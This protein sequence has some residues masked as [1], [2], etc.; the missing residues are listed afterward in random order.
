MESARMDSA[1]FRFIQNLLAAIRADRFCPWIVIA[2]IS[3]PAGYLCAQPD[4]LKKEEQIQVMAV[5]N[6][7][8]ITRQQLGAQCLRRFG[9]EVLESIVNKQLVYNECQRQGVRI[10]EQDVN[11]EIKQEAEKFGMSADR[12]T[13]LITTQRNIT[14]DRYKNDIV[15]TKLALKQ[16][17]A[18]DL[19]VTE[20]EIQHRMEF[21]FGAKVQVREIVVHDAE[22]ANRIHQQVAQNPNAFERMAVENSVNPTSASV[23]GLL[24]PIRKNSGM[25]Q[26]EQVAFSLQPGQVSDVFQ[27]ENSYI[28]LKCE[29]IFP[30]MQLAPDQLAEVR[31]RIVDQITND[32]LSTAATQLFQRLQ[33]EVKITNVVNDPVLS[34]KMPGVAAMV[35]DIQITKRYLTEECIARYGTAVLEMEITRMMLMQALRQA[36]QQVTPEDLNQEMARAAEAFGYVKADGTADMDRWLQF[37]SQ[38]DQDKIDFYVEDEVWRTVALKNLVADRVQVT[39]D[40]MK[41]GFEANYGPRVKVLAIVLSDHRTA[42][43][44]WQ[45]ATAN[46]TRDYFGQLAN[47]YSVEPA[48]KNNFGEVPPIQKHGGRPE[49]ER[50]AFSLQPGKLSKVVQVG[51]HWVIMYC[52]G[53]TTP[54]VTDFDAV[55]DELARHILE[56]KTR[57]AMADEFDRLYRSAQVDNFLTGTSQIGSRPVPSTASR[58]GR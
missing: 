51:E 37:V 3:W 5:V 15:W 2:L 14:L 43:K 58:P 21:E 28:M 38:G 9:E 29:R 20:Q 53:R 23:G 42:L 26:F 19:Q 30:A 24:P 31:E 12:Y 56:K 17:A 57:V 39:D 27:I 34:K 47:Q 49:L 54:R 11:D 44:V 52:L 50:E 7:Q 1:M 41:K 48:S 55:R 40:D 32:K 45:M 25:P 35:D 4:A 18:R 22:L 46:P 16:L 36:G 10:T 8:P 33:Q 13:K 6:G